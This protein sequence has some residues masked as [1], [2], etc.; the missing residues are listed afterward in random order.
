MLPSGDYVK[1]TRKQWA[2]WNAKD[3]V[4]SKSMNV[5]PFQVIEL[6]DSQIIH[7]KTCNHVSHKERPLKTS[8]K[9]KNSN[10]LLTVA[11]FFKNMCFL[12]KR[13]CVHEKSIYLHG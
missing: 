12:K 4:Q 1:T 5:T 9:V 6:E 7:A 13:S 2:T 3:K 10:C 8:D 11:R